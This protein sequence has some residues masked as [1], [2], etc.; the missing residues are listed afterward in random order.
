[1]LCKE[2]CHHFLRLRGILVFEE[3][4]H[5]SCHGRAICVDDEVIPEVV[6]KLLGMIADK[7]SRFLGAFITI[8]IDDLGSLDGKLLPEFLDDLFCQ[9]SQ[10]HAA[11]QTNTIR[12]PKERDRQTSSDK[13]QTRW[14]SHQP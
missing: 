9:P 2:L 7:C 1:M 12:R 5:I 10:I 6:H 13:F 14:R 8:A 3:R 4:L 11:S